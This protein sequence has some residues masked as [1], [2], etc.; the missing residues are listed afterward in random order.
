MVDGWSTLAPLPMLAMRAGSL[1]LSVPWSP[2]AAAVTAV[3]LAVATQMVV[4]AAPVVVA[5]EAVV[6]EV[7]AQ[8][9]LVAASL[10]KP[11]LATLMARLPPTVLVS[12]MWSEQSG[13]G[14]ADYPISPAAHT[15]PLETEFTM[16][17]VLL[18]ASLIAGTMAGM[19]MQIGTVHASQSMSC[20][21]ARYCQPFIEACR[22]IDG[23]LVQWMDANGGW[24][25]YT[26]TVADAGAASRLAPLVSTIQPPADDG[27][28]DGGGPSSGGGGGGG[29]G[30]G[31]DE[32]VSG[33][34]AS[35][36]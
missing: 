21:G 13:T 10:D 25:E 27:N 12:Q 34:P 32:G 31:P 20:S 4:V 18:S 7:Q 5:L 26:C 6:A 1:R 30:G 33:G 3:A 2:Q 36:L 29:G 17:R 15:R 19:G 11:E 8:A 24:L 9:L 28:D 35:I 22:Q 23:D 16:H 14:R